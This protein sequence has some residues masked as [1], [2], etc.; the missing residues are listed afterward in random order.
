MDDIRKQRTFFSAL[1][2]IHRLIDR[3]TRF[4]QNVI[5]GSVDISTLLAE[6][7][8]RI[9][10]TRYVVPFHVPICATSYARN[11]PLVRLITIA[12]NVTSSFSP[13]P[14]IINEML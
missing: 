7:N 13:N 5:N 12:N 9:D 14:S 10:S 8:F 3:R 11:N 1:L 2:K 4:L 6:L